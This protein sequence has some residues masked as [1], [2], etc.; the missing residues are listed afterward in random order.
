MAFEL[1]SVVPWGRNLAE[2]QGMFNLTEADLGRRIISFGDGPAGFNAQM[3]ALGH[4]V[5]SLDP[6][7]QFSRDELAGRIRETRDEVL[8]QVERNRGNF[9]WTHIRD[10]ADLERIR[11]GAM[12]R[13]LADYEDGRREGRY[14]PHALPDRT[15]YAD[16]AFDL[17]LSSHFL[18]LYA[19]LGLDFH[20]QSLRE[21]LRICREV[22]I[23]PL[24]DL[25]A[26]E[27]AVLPGITGH[28]G[29]DH[30]LSVEPVAYEF[31]RGGN[32]MLR[33]VKHQNG[34]A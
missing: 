9:V 1:K 32:R 28:F 25:N 31:Q 29:A 16:D 11:M 21:M 30:A 12:E 2:Y 17:G 33:I 15:P 23:F 3:H 26:G 27:S 14:V 6:I 8:A 22:R 13:F 20:L 4:R 19:N 7:Y 34:S 18:V 5:V 24:L 10:V